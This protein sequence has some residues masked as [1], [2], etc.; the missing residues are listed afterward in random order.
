MQT[1]VGPSC[2]EQAGK[3]I[4]QAGQ[5][6]YEAGVGQ[7]EQEICCLAI[8]VTRRTSRRKA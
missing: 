3:V 6:C 7:L 8:Q 4:N 1:A 2:I 5:D